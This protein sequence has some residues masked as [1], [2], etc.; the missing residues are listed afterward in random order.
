MKD[1]RSFEIDLKK[2]ATRLE[3]QENVL[4]KYDSLQTAL[5]KYILQIK[6]KFEVKILEVK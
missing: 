6:K 4:E 1:E 2:T 5:I 3:E